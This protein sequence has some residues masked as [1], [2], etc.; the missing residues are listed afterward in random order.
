MRDQ[1]SNDVSSS[2]R[3]VF[4]ENTQE[5]RAIDEIVSAPC[6]FLDT[7]GWKEAGQ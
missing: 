4:K 1:K 7:A 3:R 6:A 5:S 2:I